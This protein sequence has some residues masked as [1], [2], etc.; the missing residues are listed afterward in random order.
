MR[1]QAR[2]LAGLGQNAFEQWYCSL[3]GEVADENG[4]CMSQAQLTAQQQQAMAPTYQT[5][6]ST[7]VGYP[8]STTVTGAIPVNPTGETDQTTAVNQQINAQNA[9]NCQA[10]GGV[11]NSN[12][13]TCG[14]NW[15]PWMIG[16]AA[17]LVVVALLAKR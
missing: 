10:S 5:T 16:G 8:S 12:T 17:L 4:D 9:A 6:P 2:A 14:T 7:P 11:W 1:V 13:G 15:V 3:F